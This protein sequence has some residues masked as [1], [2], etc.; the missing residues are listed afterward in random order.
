MPGRNIQLV[1]ESCYHVLNRGV[2]SQKV[3]NCKR[4]YYQFIDRMD[5]YRN[6]NLPMG[7]AQLMN[8]PLRIK[9]DLLNQLEIKKDFLIDII[10]F[11]LMPNHFHLLLKQKINNGISKF[12]SNLS[13]SF[14][15]YYNVKHKRIGTL[16]QGRFKAVLVKSDEQLIHLSRYIHSNPYSAGLVETLSELKRYPYSSL[17]EFISI[18]KGFCKPDIV[19]GQFA[20]KNAY[21]YFIGDHA[22]YQQNLEIIKKLALEFQD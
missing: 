18:R 12:L 5:Y 4:D 2:A 20:D 19:I 14:T 11:C 1:N 3:F 21:W 22:D 15:R 6:N 10:A 17:A 7:F 16:L 13:N 9:S 8:L